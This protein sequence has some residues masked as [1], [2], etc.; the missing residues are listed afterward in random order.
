MG[1]LV[2]SIRSMPPAVMS[3][4]PIKSAGHRA[5][6]SHRIGPWF[7]P[8]SLEPHCCGSKRVATAHCAP[9][10]TAAKMAVATAGAAGAFPPPFGFRLR[11]RAFFLAAG[12]PSPVEVEAGTAGVSCRKEHWAPK[13][14]LPWGELYKA[15]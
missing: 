3:I 10:A 6:A 8:S 4:K 14:Q 11:D 12:L 2:C 9:N 1:S 15:R 7:E 5:S 13:R